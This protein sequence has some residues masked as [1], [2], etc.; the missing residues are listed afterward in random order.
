MTIEQQYNTVAFFGSNNLNFKTSN[1]FGDLRL[2]IYNNLFSM[3]ETE[4]GP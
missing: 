3:E 4:I 1:D 2:K